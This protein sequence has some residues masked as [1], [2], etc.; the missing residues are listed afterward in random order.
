MKDSQRKAKQAYRKRCKRLYI[1]LYGTDQD[2]IDHLA[3]LDAI[4]SY[5]KALIRADIEKDR[6]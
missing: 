5:I 4:P 2:I 6:E 1:D 3:K